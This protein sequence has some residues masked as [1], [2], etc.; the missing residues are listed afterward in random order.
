METDRELLELAA[1]AVGIATD[2]PAAHAR[3]IGNH[4]PLWFHSDSR[5]H[6]MCRQPNRMGNVPWNPLAD[7]GDC[8]RLETA[9]S[10]ELLWHPDG[11]QVGRRRDPTACFQFFKDHKGDRN[12]TRRHTSVSAAAEIGKAS[13][14]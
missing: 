1:K 12:A 3:F 2:W 6:P 5:D 9:L 11:V 14:V 8:A 13:N 4:A 10:L 7:D